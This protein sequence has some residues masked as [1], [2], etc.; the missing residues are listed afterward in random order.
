MGRN[1]VDPSLGCIL[2][3]SSCMRLHSDRRLV[4]GEDLVRTVVVAGHTV[5]ADRVVL[6]GRQ[7]N[8]VAGP[9]E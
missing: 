8:Q 5:V 9:I 3:T 2:A 6:L 1:V 7:G 4:E